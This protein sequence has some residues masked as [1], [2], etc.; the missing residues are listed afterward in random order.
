MLEYDS[1][2]CLGMFRRDFIK[3][4][5]QNYGMK[6]AFTSSTAVEVMKRKNKSQFFLKKKKS[7]IFIKS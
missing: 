4:N 1:C 6:N 5:K 2:I 3:A 7:N